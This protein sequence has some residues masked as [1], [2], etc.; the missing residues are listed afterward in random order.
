MSS[1][2]LNEKQI[3]LVKNL[4]KQGQSSNLENWNNWNQV[5]LGK[6]KTTQV[7]YNVVRTTE[8]QEDDSFLVGSSTV[9]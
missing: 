6:L 5:H 7:H 4:I 3:E 9:I 8:Q 2:N 1:V